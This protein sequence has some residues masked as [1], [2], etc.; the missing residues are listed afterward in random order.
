[1]FWNSKAHKKN[2][3]CLFLFWTWIPTICRWF[4]K[5]CVHVFMCVALIFVSF[6]NSGCW[7]N[8]A[9]QMSNIKG[10]PFRS[11]EVGETYCI[12]I[13]WHIELTKP[14]SR[15]KCT[16]ICVLSRKKCKAFIAKGMNE[17]PTPTYIGLFWP[18]VHVESQHHN[19]WF[20]VDDIHR[21][22]EGWMWAYILKHPS[23]PFI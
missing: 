20:Y 9:Q 1:M 13:R 5:N 18:K 7:Y 23:L 6:D 3:C 14:R 15:V 8:S 21:C 19:F 12:K 4:L 17:T 10:V 16:T 11:Q 2:K 22:V